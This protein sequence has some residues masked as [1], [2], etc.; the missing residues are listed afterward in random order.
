MTNL[1]NAQALNKSTFTQPCTEL[2]TQI[3]T[4]TPKIAAELIAQT[5]PTVQRKS[6]SAQINYLKDQILGNKWQ[7]NGDAIRQD[8]KGNI[9]DGLHRLKACVAADMAISTIFIKGLPT[10]AIKT[11]DQAGAKRTLGDYIAI[12]YA[13]SKYHN[14]VAA[15]IQAIFLYEKKQFSIL[16]IKSTVS[17][18]NKRL[19][20]DSVY[21]DNFL[22]KNPDFFKFIAHSLAIRAQGD[23]IVIPKTFTSFHWLTSQINQA[24]ADDFMYKLS[25]GA[26]IDPTHPIF[27]LRKRIII[28]KTDKKHGSQAKL[29]GTSM[30]AILHTTW[31][32][33]ITGQPARKNFSYKKVPALLNGN[34]V[35]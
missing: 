30:L 12:Q 35:D 34:L 7:L 19:K 15:C 27:A 25:T 4:I 29:N 2:T 22:S 8:V 18:S 24:K 17:G 20:I 31:N 6:K 23:R 32:L 28:S 33:Y 3:T 10:D 9:I 1:S 14:S 21:M 26:G 5:D 16:G 13:E 11:I